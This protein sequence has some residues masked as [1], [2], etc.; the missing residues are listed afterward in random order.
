MTGSLFSEPKYMNE[1]GFEDVVPHIHT[2]ITPS[3]SPEVT[4]DALSNFDAI[5]RLNKNKN[6]TL[7][8]KR[9]CHIGGIGGI[10]HQVKYP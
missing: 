5:Y 1:V 2:K 9:L 10:N 8:G 6:F 4:S 3:L 7:F